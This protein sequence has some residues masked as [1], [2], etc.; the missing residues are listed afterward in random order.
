MFTM[1]FVLHP[2]AVLAY[3]LAYREAA[4]ETWSYL[5]SLE[6]MQWTYDLQLQKIIVGVILLDSMVWNSQIANH[7]L[8]ELKGK[9][10]WKPAS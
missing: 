3:L 6:K 5:L 8:N 1:L 2:A 9:H 7:N 4:S 10:W